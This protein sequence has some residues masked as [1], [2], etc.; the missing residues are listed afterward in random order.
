MERRPCLKE[1]KKQ[2]EPE[3]GLT[4]LREYG[5]PKKDFFFVEVHEQCGGR[6]KAKVESLEKSSFLAKAA[7]REASSVS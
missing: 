6:K 2:M 1:Q 3:T 5:V 7:K 4:R